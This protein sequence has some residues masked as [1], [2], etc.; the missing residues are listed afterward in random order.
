MCVCIYLY[1]CSH[2]V[3][4]EN[5]ECLHSAWFPWDNTRPLTDPGDLCFVVL[6]G[7][8]LG[9]LASTPQPFS[10]LCTHPCPSLSGNHRHICS[11]G[12]L[13]SSGNGG[14][15]AVHMLLSTEPSPQ[16][17]IIGNFTSP[18][19]SVVQFI[20]EEDD[21]QYDQYLFSLDTLSNFSDSRIC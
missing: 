18:R 13:L 1:L 2:V 5:V 4:P 6:F 10:C 15:H 19:R 20:I 17:C 11:S 8:L 14:P 16:T 7:F 12:F 9:S 21:T 3:R